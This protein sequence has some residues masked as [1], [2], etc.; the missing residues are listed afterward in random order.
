MLTRGKPAKEV[1]QEEVRCGPGLRTHEEELGLLIGK[2]KPKRQKV[3]CIAPNDIYLSQ[4]PLFAASLG[5]RKGRPRKETEATPRH[6]LAWKRTL[7]RYCR[8]GRHRRRCCLLGYH[9]DACKRAESPFAIGATRTAA[10]R[11]AVR[12]VARTCVRGRMD[13][14]SHRAS[15]RGGGQWVLIEGLGD[16]EN[17]LWL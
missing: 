10:L 13:M 12:Q 4:M 14:R 9:M 8:L 16:D 2:A 7:N 3:L 17:E 1:Q 15:W 11:R 6:L 5:T